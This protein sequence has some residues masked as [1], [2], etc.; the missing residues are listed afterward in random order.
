[1]LMDFNN[2]V[3]LGCDFCIIY[4]YVGYYSNNI[5]IKKNEFKRFCF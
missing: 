1:M 4:I 2:L 3:I 5:I